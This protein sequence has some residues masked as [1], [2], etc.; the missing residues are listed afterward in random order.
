[1]QK[2]K[3]PEDDT[4]TETEEESKSTNGSNNG[5]LGNEERENSSDGPKHM[6]IEWGKDKCSD[7]DDGKSVSTLTVCPNVAK[8]GNLTVVQKSN[9]LNWAEEHFFPGSKIMTFDEAKTNET[10][11]KGICHA[12][13]INDL[14]WAIVGSEAIKRLR[15]AMSD[16]LSLNRKVVKSLYMG[17]KCYVLVGLIIGT[18]D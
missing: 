14:G 2:E 9:L 4:I 17:K 6:E 7:E 1:V 15:T 18:S 3:D 10:L 12:I 11:R 5:G 13:G 8:D 16:R